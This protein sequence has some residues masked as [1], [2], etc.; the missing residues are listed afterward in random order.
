M[1]LDFDNNIIDTLFIRELVKILPLLSQLFD[2]TLNLNNNKLDTNSAKKL[3][4]FLKSRK[5]CKLVL[6]LSGNDIKAEG[7]DELISAITTMELLFKIKLNVRNSGIKR[8]L[9]TQMK[10]DLEKKQ[11][12]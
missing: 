10:I 9:A 3:A 1:C 7:V 2:L 6:N 12:R 5:Y 8:G 4:K 11:G